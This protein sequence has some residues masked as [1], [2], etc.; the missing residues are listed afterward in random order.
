LIVE[1]IQRRIGH[2][3]LSIIVPQK[4]SCTML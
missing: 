3:I 2:V 1:A 4:L